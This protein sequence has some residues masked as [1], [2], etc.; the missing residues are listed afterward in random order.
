LDGIAAFFA[1]S[2]DLISGTFNTS[3]GFLCRLVNSGE[4]SDHSVRPTGL[5]GSTFGLSESRVKTAQ[6]C[7]Q[8]VNVANSFGC[9]KSNFL[10]DSICH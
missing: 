10:D 3:F 9:F 4:T 6:S 1:K 5:T 8:I 2:L 7:G